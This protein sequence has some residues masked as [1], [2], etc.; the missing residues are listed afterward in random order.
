MVAAHPDRQLE[1]AILG[2]FVKE[3]PGDVLTLRVLVNKGVAYIDGCVDNYGQKKVIARLAAS[4]PGLRKVVN[5]LRVVPATLVHDEALA[6]RVRQAVEAHP[7]LAGQTIS[8]HSKEGVVELSGTVERLSLRLHAEDA[9]WSVSG[10]RQVLN[11]LGVSYASLPEERKQAQ[12]IAQ[13]LQDCLGLEPWRISV[14]VDKGAAYLRGSV[15][16][17]ALF[18][19]AEDLVRWHPHVR[20]VVNRLAV[21]SAQSPR[22]YGLTA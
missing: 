12:L 13:H 22:N 20:D 8:V 16:S 7:S 6:E 11:K 15:P 17:F 2:A 3:R 1:E 14:E 4:A 18:Q 9:A 19:A 21:E 5:R 10:V